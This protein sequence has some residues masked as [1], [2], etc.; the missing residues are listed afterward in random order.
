MKGTTKKIIN[1]RF[2]RYED[3]EKKLEKLAEQGL[4]LE[5]CGSL[6]WTFRK[7]VPKKLKYTVTYFSEGSAFNPGITDNQQTYF[8]YAKAAGWDFVAQLNQMQIFCS[9]ADNP[10]PFETDEKEKLDNIKRCMKK[11]FIPSMFMI[12]LI[13]ILNM[14]L[15]FN[16]FQRDPIDFLSDTGRLF[17]VSMIFVGTIYVMYS[18]L[19][20]FAWCKRSERSIA[21]GGGCAESSNTIHKIVDTLFIIFIFG[22]AGYILFHIAFETGWIILLFIAQMPILTFVFWTSI[23]Y[24]KRKKVSA[25]K[26]KVISVTVLTIVSFAYI[27]F[28]MIFVIKFGFNTDNSSEYRTV[29][30]PVNAAHNREYKL[31]SDD[32][33]LTCEDLY[34]AI[35]YDYY[36]YERKADSTLFLSKNTY[37]QNSLPAKNS[38]PEIEY[39]ILETQYDFVYQLSKENLLEIPEW[40][41]NTGFEL[42]D[43]KIFETTEAYQRYYDDDNP[44]GEYILLFDSKIIVLNM[45]KPPTQKQVEVIKEKLQI[46]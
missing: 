39:V 32:I 11:S 44:T 5:E 31:Y 9:E 26:N 28:I 18:L 43:N 7:G 16:S 27:A 25:V 29:S 36:S 19:D 34:G 10:I 23:K 3:A 35:D 41:D 30:W 15:Q 38:P 14:F 20:Y 17:S 21:S 12:I 24:L 8:D 40:R 42:I 13:F 1:F 45:E 33:P 6:L 46:W 2:D 22:F 37:R 4:F